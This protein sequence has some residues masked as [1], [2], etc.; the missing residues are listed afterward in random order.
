MNN[1]E[2]KRTINSNYGIDYSQASVD[3]NDVRCSLPA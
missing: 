1:Q 3:C 2:M